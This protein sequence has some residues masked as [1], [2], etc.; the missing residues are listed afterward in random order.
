MAGDSIKSWVSDK[1]MVVLGY[2]QPA[3]VDY[4]IAMGKL[5]LTVDFIDLIMIMYLTINWV[6][7]RD[8]AQSSRSPSELVSELLDY[9]FSSDDALAFSQ[10]ICARLPRK[11]ADRNVSFLRKYFFFFC[12]VCIALIFLVLVFVC[13]FSQLYSDVPAR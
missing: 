13:L 3:V 12:S 6:A 10:D 11:A 1:L 2:S 7:F 4:L 8:A 5:V 9:G